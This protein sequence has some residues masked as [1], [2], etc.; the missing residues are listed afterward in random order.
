ML[1]QKS[2]KDSSILIPSIQVQYAYQLPGGD[3][4]NRFGNNSTIGGNFTLKF[5]SNLIIGVEGNYIFGSKVKDSSL[6]DYIGNEDGYIVDG[7]GKYAEV[8]LY[9][10]GFNF[11][12]NA[13]YLFSFNRP[14]P[15]SGIC[16]LA[17]AGF[18]QHKIR[19]ENPENVAYQIKGDYK[20]G[21]DKLSN[22][23][24]LKQYIGWQ[25]YGNNRLLSCGIG[26]E[27][28]QAFTQNRRSYDYNLMQKVSDK[29]VDLYFGLRVS[30]IIPFYEKAPE[31]YYYN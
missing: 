1:G 9:E 29:R 11:I 16:V 2:I 10:R 21:Y 31:M 19:I 18:L 24:C 4:K 22:G 6:F 23:L 5:P 30:W 25:F 3:L 26:V 28:V 15:N 13:G 14:N 12:A 8:F 27:A 7:D 20:K 17:G